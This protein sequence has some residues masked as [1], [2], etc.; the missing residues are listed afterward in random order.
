MPV[1]DLMHARVSTRAFLP[2]PVPTATIRDLI[3]AAGAAPSGTNIQPWQVHVV[4]GAVRD[5]ICAATRAAALAPRERPEWIYD[6][7]PK[8]WRDPYLA[9]RRAC[10]WGLYG[11]LGIQKGDRE[12]GLAQ[13]LRNF[14][15]FDAPVGLF[16]FLDRDLGRGS[17][18]DCGM[19][20]QNLMIAAV[21]QR[22][23]T[24]PQAAWVPFDGLIRSILNIPDTQMLVCGMAIGHADLAAPVNRFRPGRLAV[25]EFT[26]WHDGQTSDSEQ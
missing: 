11:L 12:A 4:T 9:R 26:T 1:T 20:L 25:D 10:G 6:Y 14:D 2:K 23:A 18:L 17:L 24:C 19:F 7:Y 3:A 5:Q 15:F 8:T 21:D 16:L 13:E 22:L